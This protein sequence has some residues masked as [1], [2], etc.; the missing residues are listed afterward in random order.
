M[1]QNRISIN[2]K[3]SKIIDK[4]KKC[5]TQKRYHEYVNLKKAPTSELEDRRKM[6]NYFF[7]FNFP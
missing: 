4:N 6:L 7:S 3:R 5:Y 2:H 1:L